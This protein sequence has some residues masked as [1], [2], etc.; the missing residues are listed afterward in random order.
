[1][2]EL[3]SMSD[4]MIGILVT[5]A[6]LNFC[7]LRATLSHPKGNPRYV[8]WI[9]FL[10]KQSLLGLVFLCANETFTI[11][12]MIANGGCCVVELEIT[13]PSGGSGDYGDYKD[14]YMF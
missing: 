6:I 12:W 3:I 13:M 14:P 10:V 7:I 1:M 2:I 11:V 4:L 9:C 5:F 8:F